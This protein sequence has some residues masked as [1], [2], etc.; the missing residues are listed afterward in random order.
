M[1]TG[2]SWSDHPWKGVHCFLY[3]ILSVIFISATH[4]M[5]HCAIPQPRYNKNASLWKVGVGKAVITPRDILWMSGYA[6][7]DKPAEGLIHDIWVKTLALEDTSGRRAVWIT[8]DIIGFSRNF[9][10]HIVQTLMLQHQLPRSAIA[11]C[12]SHN[13]S[14]PVVNENLFHIYPPFDSTMASAVRRYGKWLEKT[15]IATVRDAFEDLTPVTLTKSAGI[16]R[17]AVNRRENTAN[18][19]LSNAQIQGPYDHSVPVFTAVNPSGDPKA[20][21][22]GYACHATTL[23]G[24]HWSGDYPGFAQLALEKK[25]VGATALFFAGCAGDQ[26]PI[27]RRTVALARQYGEELCAAVARAVEE[28]IIALEPVLSTNY[29]E[30]SLKYEEP[31][32]EDSLKKVA[33]ATESYQQRWAMAQLA[34]HASAAGIP[35]QYRNYPVQVW[36]LGNESVVFMGGEVVVDYALRLK[37]K[38]GNELVVAAYA[39]DVMA[40]IPSE[41]VLREGGYEGHSSMCV[42]GHPARWAAGLEETILDAVG[43]QLE[44]LGFMSGQ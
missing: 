33:G 39:N 15:V 30:L 22:F 11:L 40:Y 28:P 9:S 12:S 34:L 10:E 27:P 16:A 23:N 35:A 5:G 25:F 18:D 14:G 32:P 38:W 42:Y 8:C 43:L 6:A 26:N 1:R 20:I 7:R 24:Y 36:R 44:A 37:E 2:K 17:F 29:R 41:R 4:E 31:P 3:T 13:H 19:V 21:V